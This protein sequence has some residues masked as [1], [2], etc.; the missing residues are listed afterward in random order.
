MK[1]HELRS[2]TRMELEEHAREL[3]QELFNLRFRGTTQ[4][5]DNPLRIR[6]ARKDLA[7]TLTVIREMDI[8]QTT[9]SGEGS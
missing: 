4:Q 9:E 3:R 6:T 2:M 7:R 8:N 1:T 5:L